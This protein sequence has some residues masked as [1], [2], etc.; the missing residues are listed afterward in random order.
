[1]PVDWK[2]L[3]VHLLLQPDLHKLAGTDL[4]LHGHDLPQTSRVARRHGLGAC[5]LTGTVD[6]NQ[7]I[8]SFPGTILVSLLDS[9]HTFHILSFIH[10]VGVSP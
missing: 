3:S 1:M 2:H 6:A 10:G 4:Q 9:L 7:A 5:A 8:A